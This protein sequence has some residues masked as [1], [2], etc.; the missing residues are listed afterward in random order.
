MLVVLPWIAINIFP[1][2]TKKTVGSAC[3]VYPSE[4]HL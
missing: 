1:D 3:R 2:E 4:G